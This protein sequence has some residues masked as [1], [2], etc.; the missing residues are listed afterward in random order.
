MEPGWVAV[1]YMVMNKKTESVKDAFTFITNFT[2]AEGQKFRLETGGN[3]VP[4]V[5]SGADEVVTQGSDLEGA[6]YFLDVRDTGL[7][8][9][10]ELNVPGLVENMQD[11]LEKRLWLPNGDGD[12]QGAL[13]EVAQ[14]A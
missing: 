6:E 13:D 8:G 12:V 2:S 1:A 7:V 3:A 4:S 10:A 5:T 9:Y 14:L 11:V